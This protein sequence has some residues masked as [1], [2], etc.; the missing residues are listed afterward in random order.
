M[1]DIAYS[2]GLEAESALSEVLVRR[3][4]PGARLGRA[5]RTRAGLAV[6]LAASVP[7]SYCERAPR[8]MSTAGVANYQRK[9]YSNRRERC[10]SHKRPQVRADKF[11]AC[12]CPRV[13]QSRCGMQYSRVAVTA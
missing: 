3:L 8:A 5:R 9:D 11:G 12:V 13:G 1:S 6:G 10:Q 4:L 2:E 7:L